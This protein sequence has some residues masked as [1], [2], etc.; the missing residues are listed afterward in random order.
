MKIPIVNHAR[1]A[2]SANCLWSLVS[3]SFGY[4]GWG[5]IG[6]VCVPLYP[7]KRVSGVG[8]RSSRGGWCLGARSSWKGWVSGLTASRPASGGQWNRALPRPAT[9]R[10]HCVAQLRERVVRARGAPSSRSR[11]AGRPPCFRRRQRR[12]SVEH[13]GRHHSRVWVGISRD[14]H[15]KNAPPRETDATTPSAAGQALRPRP[16]HSY[17]PR[18]RS[19]RRSA[20]RHTR[21][22]PS[23]WV[24]GRRPAAPSRRRGR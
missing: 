3:V 8:S 2:H 12:L 9:L 11:A 18:C 24:A 5:W 7:L 20:H 19:R 22:S 6:S 17:P 1:S 13:L 14:E 15:E 4:L 16:A 10:E 21:W 23:F